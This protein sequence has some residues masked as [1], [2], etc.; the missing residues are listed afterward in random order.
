[1]ATEEQSLRSI[2]EH[3]ID[4]QLFEGPSMVQLWA[5]GVIALETA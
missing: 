3:E 5:T 1:M 4:V 2:Y